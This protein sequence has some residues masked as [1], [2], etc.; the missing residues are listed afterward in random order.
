MKISVGKFTFGFLLALCF[1]SV[2]FLLWKVTT[3]NTPNSLTVTGETVMSLR[4]DDDD[5][6]EPINYFVFL[7][8][9]SAG[10]PLPVEQCLVVARFYSSQLDHREFP[11]CYSL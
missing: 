5:Q 1:R 9:D 6:T 3:Q 11:A 2:G 4:V 10:Q 8:V 7:L